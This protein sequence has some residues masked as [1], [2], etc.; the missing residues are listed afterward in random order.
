MFSREN[1]GMLY[2]I[3][4]SIMKLQQFQ[5]TQPFSRLWLQGLEPENTCYKYL[6]DEQ[7]ER[8]DGLKL[9]YINESKDRK[10][11]LQDPLNWLIFELMN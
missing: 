11:K 10:T 4:F 3:P 6:K 8:P 5:A 1:Q 9:Q 7:S 2:Q